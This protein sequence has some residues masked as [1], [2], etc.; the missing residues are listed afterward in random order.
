MKIL[1]VQ[2]PYV[3][4]PGKHEQ[5]PPDPPMGLAYLAAY[6]R[7]QLAGEIDVQILDAIAEGL[8]EQL[9]AK[10]IAGRRPDV[11]GY[12]STTLT[13]NVVKRVAR[14][15]RTRLPDAFQVAGG[16]H[17]SSM[18]DDMLPSLDAAV[19][20]EG[21]KTLCDICERLLAGE[22]MSEIP[23]TAIIQDGETHRA[24]PRPLVDNLD[25]LP[26]PARDLLPMHKYKH[27]YPI[28]KPNDRFST[29]YTSRGCPWNCTFCAKDM[30]WGSQARFR[31]PDNVLA[32]LEHLRA[33]WNPS[34]IF[35][36]DDTFTTHRRRVL[37]LCDRFIEGRFD[38]RWGCLTRA[39]RLDDELITAMRRAGCEDIQIGVESGSEEIL[40][41]MSKRQPL[42]TI[43]EAFRI[44]RQHK[45]RTKGTFLLGYFDEDAEMLRQ[46]IDFALE[47]DPTY[48]F[49]SIFVPYPGTEDYAKAEK[50]GY[51]ETKD[52]D[53]FN[54]HG[55][56]VIHTDHF[57]G[58]ELEAWR[59]QAYRRFYLRPGKL[60]RYAKDT[61]VTGGF[62][63]MWSNF[64][65]FLDLS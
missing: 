53:R 38:F 54:F 19:I 6:V 61:L 10:D 48:A 51:F 32:E 23:G 17:P 11:V 39:D 20:G 36:Y 56:P 60:F 45:I 26:F 34:Y 5:T 46:T 57:T 25:D 14:Q 41:T 40:Q 47:L 30:I 35:F 64:M 43:R 22:G 16:A 18:P 21:E 44:L 55:K 9:L 13:A 15:V 8:D 2:P 7:T 28:K 59:R 62:R 42:G 24:I 58:E 33:E 31:S 1:L 65:A 49:F 4:V 29:F 27:E 12:T 63:R 3:H 52:W 37:D 50:L